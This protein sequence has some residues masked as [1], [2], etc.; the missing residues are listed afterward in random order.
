MKQPRA[1]EQ[2]YSTT[3][4]TAMPAT[5]RGIAAHRHA[6]REQIDVRPSQTE[7][8]AASAARVQRQHYERREMIEVAVPKV[9]SSS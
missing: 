8:L 5:L 9:G 7:Q 1:G 3:H 6:S 4:G 2:L